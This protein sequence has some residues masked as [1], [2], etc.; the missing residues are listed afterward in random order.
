M[1][2][3]LS[4]LTALVEYQGSEL[5]E[6][7]APGLPGTTSGLCRLH[8]LSLKDSYILLLKIKAIPLFA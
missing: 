7:P 5:P 6:T 8:P 2:Q 3:R 4:V 1:S